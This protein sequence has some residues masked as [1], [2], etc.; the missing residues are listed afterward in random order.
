MLFLQSCKC[1]FF[2][3]SWGFCIKA[4]IDNEMKEYTL[5]YNKPFELELPI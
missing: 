2:P 1:I 3:D 5:Y 4:I